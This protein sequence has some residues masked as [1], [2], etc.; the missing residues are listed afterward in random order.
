MSLLDQGFLET[1]E[2]IAEEPRQK[3]RLDSGRME[4]V[5]TTL[6]RDHFVTLS[7]LAELVN[8]HPDG[9]RQQYLSKMVRDGRMVLAFPTKP[10]H[11]RQAYR[12][13]DGTTQEI[14]E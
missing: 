2:Q 5:V 14:A 6:C 11:E 3:E 7:A 12:A 13:A 10:T 9:L 4:Q 8:R 1:L